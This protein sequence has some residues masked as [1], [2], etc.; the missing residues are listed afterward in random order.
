[1]S[2][3][4]KTRIGIMGFGQVGRQ[5][6]CLAAESEDVEIAVI[7]D[8]GKPEILH[9]LV[10]SDGCCDCVLEGNYLRNSRFRTRML[11]NHTPGDIPWDVFG[12]DMV[13]DATGKFRD[14]GQL[15]P[16]LDSGARRVLITTL[17]NSSLDSMIVP[18]LNDEAANRED[19]FISSSSPTTAAFALTLDILHK[20]LGVE[21]ATMTTVH[22]YTSDQPL[23]DYAGVDFRRSRSAAVNIIPN[24]NDSAKWVETLLPQF[25]GKLSGHALNVPVQRGSMLDLS[26]VMNSEQVSAEDVNNAMIAAQQKYPG[27][28]TT[29]D[30]PIVSSDVIGNRHSVVFDLKGTLK[31]GRR[32][33][34]SLAWYDT[35]GHACRTLDVVRLYQSLDS[36][37]VAQ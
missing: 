18:G 6:Y 15:Q 20:A 33:V 37:E 1:M 2:S 8:I 27:V 19:R 36:K 31:S 13:I 10:S 22:A 21:A 7:S 11:Q 23:Q 32:M 9:Y 29:I 34:K 12:V 14:A 24:T 16:H 28:V 4:R 5:L 25:T 35:L 3:N 17:P 26:T 30:D